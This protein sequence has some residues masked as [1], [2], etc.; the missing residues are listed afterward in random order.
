MHPSFHF[1]EVLVH[2]ELVV[3]HPHVHLDLDVLD[4]GVADALVELR[5]LQF[6]RIKLDELADLIHPRTDIISMQQQQS[7]ALDVESQVMLDGLPELL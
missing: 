6:L 3:L 2:L 1:V 4:E 7:F 5:A